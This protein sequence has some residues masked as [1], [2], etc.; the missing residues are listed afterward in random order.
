MLSTTYKEWSD[1]SNLTTIGKN[2]SDHN[3]ERK[4]VFGLSKIQDYEQVH[5]CLISVYTQ[6][7]KGT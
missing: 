1:G 2:F 7:W 4:L 6:T 5:K 3:D